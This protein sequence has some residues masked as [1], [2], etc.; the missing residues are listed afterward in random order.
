M[1]L[2][3]LPKLRSLPLLMTW[4]RA[5]IGP[6][7]FLLA[8]LW[9]NPI[10]FAVCLAVAFISDIFDGIVARRLGV[11]IPALRRFDS[12]ADSIFYMCALLAVWLL[13]R[14]VIMENLRLLIALLVIEG[15]RYAFDFWKFRREA[16]YHM[17]SS[18]LWGI[19]LF[20]G[21][22]SALV[23]GNGGLPVIVAVVVG[24][25]ADLEGLLISFTLK[26]WRHDVPTII[27]A[28]KI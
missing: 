10:A 27:H 17:W 23:F 25:I 24:I 21:F 11:A 22:F 5:G 4:S 20:V 26:S 1:A 8:V 28:L 9:P 3:T 19:A 15:L 13:Y 14:T 18:K 7:V 6:V 16:S 12:I 2:T